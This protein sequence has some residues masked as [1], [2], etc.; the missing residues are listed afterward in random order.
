MNGVT[1]L[2]AASKT[3]ERVFVSYFEEKTRRCSLVPLINFIVSVEL[4]SHTAMSVNT[5]MT[6]KIHPQYLQLKHVL[7]YYIYYIS[8]IHELAR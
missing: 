1:L 6:T 7:R 3:V 2:N 4:L 8:G 5:V